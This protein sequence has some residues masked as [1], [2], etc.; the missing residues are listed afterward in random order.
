MSST[1]HGTL[2]H[3]SF[4]PNTASLSTSDAS[5]TLA[6]KSLAKFHNVLMKLS[7]IGSKTGLN[8]RE[9][10]LPCMAVVEAVGIMSPIYR[11]HS[12][13]LQNIGVLLTVP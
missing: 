10:V 11:T 13:I 8:V 3:F 1:L 12:Y 7:E 9:M 6:G 4:C 5:G 2:L